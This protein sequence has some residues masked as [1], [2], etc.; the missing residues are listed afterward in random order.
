[1]KF[2]SKLPV[3]LLV[4]IV[5]SSIAADAPARNQSENIVQLNFF[6]EIDGVVSASFMSVEGLESTTE[7]IEFHEGIWTKAVRKIPGRTSFSNIILKRPFTFSSE[8]WKWRKKVADGN[9]ERR[10]GRIIITGGNREKTVRFEFYDAWPVRWKLSALAD[11]E[12]MRLIEELEIA[13][14]NLELRLAGR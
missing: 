6:V 9:A 14:E 10:N 7:A 2:Y 3:V 4:L 13:I 12:N 5:I 11:R 1:M 8:L